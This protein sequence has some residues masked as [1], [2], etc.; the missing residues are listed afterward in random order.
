MKYLLLLL[1]LMNI[2]SCNNIKDKKDYYMLDYSNKNNWLYIPENSQENEVDVFYLYP[3]TWIRNNNDNNLISDINDKSMREGASNILAFQEELFEEVASIYAPFY[4]QADFNYLLSETNKI[5]E[6]K[7]NKYFYSIPKQDV[8]NAFEYY[9]KNYNKQRPFILF[10]DS[11]GAMMIKEILKEYIN[12]NDTLQRRLVA[13]YIIGYSITEDDLNT[14]T[15]LRFARSEYDTGVIISYNTESKNYSNYNPTLLTNSISI[16]PIT[17]ILDEVTA[18]SNISLGSKM[19]IDG[20]IKKI[21][22]LAS[23]KVDK[24]RGVIKCDSIKENNFYDSNSIYPKGVYAPYNV[25]LYFYD[26]KEN[27]RKRVSAFWKY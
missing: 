18:T 10:G 21:N 4:R 19:I 26:L 23:A 2:I 1:I 11:Q 12:T 20:E 24:K 3:T 7:K 8:F 6:K 17:W 15:N 9:L 22:T 25:A 13:A 27:I 5:S 16:N 14:Y